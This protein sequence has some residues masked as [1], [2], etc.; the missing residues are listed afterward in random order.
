MTHNQPGLNTPVLI[1][2][3]V[4]THNVSNTSRAPPDEKSTFVVPSTMMSTTTDSINI[5]NSSHNMSNTEEGK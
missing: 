1:K 5:E 4:E 2:L 3:T